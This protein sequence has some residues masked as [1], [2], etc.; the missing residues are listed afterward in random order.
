[1]TIRVTDPVDLVKVLPYQLGYHPSDSLALVGLRG[2]H[3]G[4]VQRGDLATRPDDLAALVELMVANLRGDGC[5]AAVVIVY[6]SEPGGGA[7]AGAEL[8]RRLR[9]T[10][11]PVTEHMVVRDGQV[12]FPESPTAGEAEGGIALPADRDVPAV[13]QFVA[14][15]SNPSPSRAALAVRVGRGDGPTAARVKAAADRLD[16]LR[17]RAL[18]A[19]A[20][21]DW[22]RLLDVTTPQFGG[23]P[24]SAA[25]AARM[26]VSLLDVH[27]RDLVTAWLCPGTLELSA[28][29]PQLAALARSRLP[30]PQ[31]GES[32]I[33]ARAAVLD[34]LCWLARHT[35]DDL[36]PGILTVL[37]SY[38]WWRGDGALASVALD[39]ALGIDPA[40]R[41]AQLV[42]RM[43]TMA[44]RPECSA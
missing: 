4:V 2:R 10:G 13:A 40:Y 37:A 39:R 8:A 34:R 14:L 26:A 7:P 31:E 36:A 33:E 38:A 25:A 41:L 21:A 19:R 44:I 20:M 27:L 28:F 5:S 9:E 22:G 43:V 1:M 6:E 17:L 3:L 11:V 18:R 32:A 30:P 16:R 42:E 23:A 15:G 29:E 24:A 35:P 12:F